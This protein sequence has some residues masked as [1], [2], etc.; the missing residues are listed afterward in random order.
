MQWNYSEYTQV[1]NMTFFSSDLE[2][3]LKSTQKT[4]SNKRIELSS[5]IEKTLRTQMKLH[6]ACNVIVFI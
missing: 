3:K 5:A 2:K 6:F 1:F 4:H